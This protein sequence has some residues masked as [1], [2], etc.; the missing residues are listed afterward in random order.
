MD[1]REIESITF[2]IYSTDEVLAMAVCKLEN[3]K[4]TGYGSVY[5]DRMG[6]TDSSKACETCGETAE[7]CNG[8]FG[9]IELNEPIIHPLFYRRVVAFLNCFCHKCFRLLLLKEQ[10]YLSGL[11]K[12][13]G[14]SRFTKI[15]EKL[16]KVDMCCHEDCGFDQPKYKL[17][18]T[19]NTIHKV[20]ENRSKE[21]TSIVLSVEEILTI[22][23]NIS[24]S[25]VELLGFDPSL[26]HPRNFILEVIPVLPTCA[27]PY[28]KADGNMC[29]D[30]LTN[31]YIEIIKANNHLAPIKDS[32]NQKEISEVKRQKCL[33]S[34]KFRVFTTFNNS[35]GKAKHTTNG[36]PIKG[37]KERLAGKDGQI[38]C[39]LMGKR[40]CKYDTIIWEWNGGFKRAEDIKVGD[41]VIGDDGLPRHVID[42]VECVSPSYKIKQTQGEDY[43][44]SCE[45]ILTVKYNNHG[46]IYWRENQSKY[47]GWI[48]S[49]YDR[50]SKSIKSIKV[51]V[52]PPLSVE[53]AKNELIKFMKDNNLEQQKISWNPKRKNAGTWRINWTEEETGN[54][55]SKEIAVVIG[56][57]KEQAYEEIFNFRNTIDTDPMI[58]IHVK[59]YISLSNSEKSSLLGVK[60]NTPIQ[61]PKK[62]VF[63]DPRIL[64]MWLGDGTKNQYIFTNPD[65]ELI[66]YFKE[67]TEKQDGIFHTYPDNLHPRISNCKFLDFLRYYDLFNNKHIPEDYI[68]NDVKT[69]LELL[70]GLIDTDGS[71]EQGGSTVR[72]TQC[73]ANKAIIDGVERIANSLG[74]RTSVKIKKTTWSDKGEKKSGEALVLNISGNISIIPTLLERKKCKDAEKDMSVTKIEVVEDGIDRFCGFEVDGNNRFIL[75]KDATI[76]HNCN[77]SGRTVIGPDPTLKL[78]ELGVPK[79]MAQILTVPV[80]VTQFNKSILQ[81][82]VDNNKVDSLLKPDGKTRINLKRYRKGTRLIS[83]DIITRNGKKI[84][85][86][87]GRELIKEGDIVE[88]NGEILSKITPANRS[89]EIQEEWIVERHLEDGDYVLLNRQPTLHK[90]SMMAMQVVIK[91]HKTLRM[92]LAITKP[93]NADFNIGVKQED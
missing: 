53:D 88:R 38:R 26:A 82:L 13:K 24:D 58:D 63:L 46:K 18:T 69:R 30:D 77:Q 43:W 75:G 29:D 49:W 33:A 84:K 2:G 66:E 52:N 81:D 36:R 45:H 59:D 34:L 76:T 41:T 16:K 44:V 68:V 15:Q 35:Q 7:F 10:L 47:G 70:A 11:K 4:K 22:L 28:V 6:T 60:L 48:M 57:T 39:N 54:K 73:F 17:N 62:D 55:R 56:K 71:V 12:V 89:Y 80:R 86:I 72:I 83:G 37:I 14:E 51:S 31:Q 90:A 85:V 64:G 91:P 61:W 87:T 93:F 40:N 1:T 25:D 74:F 3:A 50:E 78:G 65:K 79:E 67:W 32:E 27:R 19:D 8:H 21:K 9:Y 42:L 23:T 5:D 92:N 20:Y